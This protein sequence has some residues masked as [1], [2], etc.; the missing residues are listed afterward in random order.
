MV[1]ASCTIDPTKTKTCFHLM[2]NVFTKICDASVIKRTCP[3][4]NK[5]C[6]PLIFSY[7]VNKKTKYDITDV[8][9]WKNIKCVMLILFFVHD[10][11]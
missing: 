2:A 8:T 11:R 6:F 10:T 5:F 4:R 3:N 9:F 1:S 7:R